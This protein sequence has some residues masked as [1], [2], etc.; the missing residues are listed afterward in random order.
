MSLRKLP[1]LATGILASVLFFTGCYHSASVGVYVST[2]PPPPIAETIVVSPGPG[3][4][5]VP[6]YQSWNGVRY[7]W[8]PGHWERVPVGRRRWIP[9]HWAHNGRGWY[10]IEGHWR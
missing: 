3:Y 6:G 5:W 9:G 7:V 8:S 10:W 4:Y 1:F 2:P